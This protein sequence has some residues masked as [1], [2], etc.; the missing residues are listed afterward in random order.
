MS[1][2]ALFFVFLSDNLVS[3]SLP[4]NH[5]NKTEQAIEHTERNLNE[6]AIAVKP[7]PGNLNKNDLPLK[8]SI[9]QPSGKAF[10][11]KPFNEHGENIGL[12]DPSQGKH[13]VDEFA[14]LAR[15]EKMLGM[16]FDHGDNCTKVL[17]QALIIGVMKC[18][19]E[20]ITT[21][22]AIHPDIAMQLKVEAVQFFDNK[23]GKGLDW[24]RNQ[25]PCSSEGQITVEKSPQYIASPYAP[26][27]IQK[28][29][30]GIKLILSIREPVKRAVSHYEHVANWSPEKIP[31]TFEKTA[32]N[33]LGGI[34]GGHETLQ[35][36]LYS[37]HLKR[38]LN[39]FNLDQIHFVDGDNFKFH[40][41][42][43][44]NKIEKFLGIRQYFTEDSFTYNQDKGFFCLNLPGGGEG[45]MYKGKGREHR[46]V[47]PDV[48]DKLKEFYKPYNEEFFRIIGRRFDWGY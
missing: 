1:C 40:P 44:L 6:S 37:F 15:K 11:F 14:R 48:I 5:L 38:W 19:T 32:I 30:K 27:R 4:V 31:D 42:E 16:K 7:S 33:S 43:E 20:T 12:V 36:S 9:E 2:L 3:V 39:Y 23:H 46:Q 25:M 41:A 35:R 8:P 34:N 17:P 13:K 10:Q 29:D 47:S 18:G 45:C 21:F 22:L 28:M 26:K 24:Y